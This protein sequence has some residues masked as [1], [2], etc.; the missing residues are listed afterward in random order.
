MKNEHPVCTQT[1]TDCDWQSKLEAFSCIEIPVKTNINEQIVKVKVM[2]RDGMRVKENTK[3]KRMR[4]DKE[5]E[6]LI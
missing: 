3:H 2:E 4:F 1:E 5:K 6:R